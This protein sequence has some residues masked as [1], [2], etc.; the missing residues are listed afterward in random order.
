[1]PT[2]SKIWLQRHIIEIFQKY[3]KDQ[4]YV[5]CLIEFTLFICIVKEG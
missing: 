2:L 4:K 3:N 1:M 5:H